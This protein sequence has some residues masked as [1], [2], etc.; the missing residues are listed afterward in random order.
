MA[1]VPGASLALGLSLF[2]AAPSP[3]VRALTLEQAL[4]TARAHQPT[5][6]SALARVGAAAADARIARAQWVPTLG[7]T[8]Q[9]IEGTTNNT[10]ASYLGVREVG[11]PRIG[12]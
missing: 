3:P 1:C 4:A 8:V 10:T 5:L 9:A 12:A 6:Q 2:A 11:L 7:A